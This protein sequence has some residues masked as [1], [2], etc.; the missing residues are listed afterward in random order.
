MKV[1]VLGSDGYIGWPL[2]RALLQAGHEVSCFDDGS[3]RRHVREL[4]SNS[5]TPILSRESRDRQLKMEY[6]INFKGWFDFS[7]GLDSVGFVYWALE[8]FQPDAIYHLA[9]QPSA[10]FSMDG[11]HKSVSTQQSNVIGTLQLLW[12]MKEKC[13]EAHLIKIGSMGEYGTPDCDI[14]EGTIPHKCL[15][16][17]APQHYCP[18]EGLPFPRSPGS[19]YHLSKVHDTNNII[20]ACKIWGL[21]ATDIMQG[22]VFGN[23]DN[24]RLDY[25]EQFGTALNRFCAQAVINHPL[26]VYGTGGQTR[27]WLCL[28]DSIQCL[29]IA[30]DNPPKQGTYR[31]YNQFESIHAVQELAAVV[32]HQAFERGIEV[33][34]K[35]YPNPRVE[36]ESHYYSPG[37][38]TL[39]GLGYIPETDI[40]KKVGELID[41]ILPHKDRIRREV[42]EPRTEW[43]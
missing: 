28:E 43:R 38:D 15:N 1:M 2:T 7:L 39:F 18:M 8:Q 41:T 16:P 42:I 36:S 21:K 9:Q 5:I 40:S 33:E 35:I 27:G 14:P 6:P 25:D 11:V 19:F 22:V 24:T 12:A 10:P 17:H 37:H 23:I 13:P 20:L 31:V 30:L 3:R 29:V 4:G 26:T 34:I 32:A